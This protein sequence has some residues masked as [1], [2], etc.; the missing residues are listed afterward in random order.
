MKMKKL[1]KPQGNSLFKIL[2]YLQFFLPF[3]SFKT[4]YQN[5]GQGYGLRKSIGYYLIL[6]KTNDK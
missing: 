4:I 6:Y 5:Y 3:S 1:P 2:C